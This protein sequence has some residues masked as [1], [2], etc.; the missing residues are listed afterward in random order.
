MN[1][2]SQQA[3]YIIET[4]DTCVVAVVRGGWNDYIATRYSKEFLRTVEQFNGQPFSHLVYFDEFTFAE[5][6]VEKMVE[7]LVKKLTQL[8]MLYVA[9]VIPPDFYNITQYQ[10]QKMTETH[11]LF[12]KQAFN[13]LSDA[14]FWLNSK[15]K[16]RTKA[17][18]DIINVYLANR[19]KKDK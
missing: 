18:E 3:D 9:Q 7:Q 5:P 2:Q 19:Y 6:S 11:G 4:V 15:S 14:S 13:S 8:N 12:E 17:C 16:I 1:Q 10:L